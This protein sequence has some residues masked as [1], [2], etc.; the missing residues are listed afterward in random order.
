MKLLF[1]LCLAPVIGFAQRN[2]ATEITLQN[3][4]VHGYV[5][6]VRLDSVRATYA[7][8]FLPGKRLASNVDVIRWYAF[9]VGTFY[10][11]EKDIMIKNADGGSLTF[12]STPGL[13]NFLDYNGWQLVEINYSPYVIILK[14]KE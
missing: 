9:D 12:G 10:R 7:Q 1:V 13:L 4:N 2:S 6:G 3:F 8:A 5:N 11:D 14:R